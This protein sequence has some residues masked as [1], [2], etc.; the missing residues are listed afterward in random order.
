MPKLFVC[1]QCGNEFKDH[2]GAERKFCSRECS[3]E[4]QKKRVDCACATCGAEF[5]RPKSRVSKNNYCSRKCRQV[6]ASEKFVD[7]DGSLAHPRAKEKLTKTCKQCNDEFSVYPSRRDQKFCDVSCKGEWMSENKVGENHPNNQKIKFECEWC[8][9]EY[10]KSPSRKDETR[11]CSRQ[12]QG[13]Y[14]IRQQGRSS[15]LEDEI[16]EILDSCC[17]NFEWQKQIGRWCVDF[18]LPQLNLVVEC[19]GEYWHSKPKVVERDARKNRFLRSEGYN[20]VR[21]SGQQIKED[22]HALLARAILKFS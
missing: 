21:L 8:G 16:A 15:S 18:Y 1:Q 17:V 14:Q 9:R 19:D 13:S 22:G 20:L 12:C 2:P 3:Y 6:A 4:S 5:T 11:F 10:K 7:L